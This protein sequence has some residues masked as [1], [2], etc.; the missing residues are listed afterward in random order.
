V[1][2]R[3]LYGGRRLPSFL[4]EMMFLLKILHIKMH[5]THLLIPSPQNQLCSFIPDKNMIFF[6]PKEKKKKKKTAS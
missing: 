4:L 1:Q 3:R 5:K 6:K 2:G